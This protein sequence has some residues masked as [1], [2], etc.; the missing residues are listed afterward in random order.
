M[1]GYWAARAVLKHTFGIRASAPTA[2]PE[3]DQ[4]AVDEQHLETIT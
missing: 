3:T 1:C 4:P 2:K